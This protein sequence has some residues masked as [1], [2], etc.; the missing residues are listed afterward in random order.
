MV[1]QSCKR[2]FQLC[3]A[4][5]WPHL[6]HHCYEVHTCSIT[7]IYSS[8][9]LRVAGI[10]KLGQSYALDSRTP[11]QPCWNTLR[12]ALYINTLLPKPPSCPSHGSDLHHSLTALL[13][14]CL[15]SY[16]P[17]RLFSIPSLLHTQS[18]HAICFLK[19]MNK[20]IP[21]QKQSEENK[22]CD[23][24]TGSLICWWTQKGSILSAV[25]RTDSPWH[26]AVVQSLKV[27][28]E[29]VW[30]N[31]LVGGECPHKCYNSGIWKIKVSKIL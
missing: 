29:E 24:G 11:R 25:Q 23:S 4:G 19:D 9:P 31:V 20:Y 28:L 26:T 2:A 8:Q 1:W 3:T 10:L 16:F 18:L 5:H 22:Q 13:A 7:S 30:Q 15:P 6:A 27:S 12:M 17:L 21:C 14:F